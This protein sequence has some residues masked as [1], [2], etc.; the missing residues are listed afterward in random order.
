MPAWLAA[1][2]HV[3]ATTPVTVMPL[4]PL[5]MQI[6]GVVEVKVTGLPEAPPVA[7]AVVVPPTPSVPGVKV[8]V[9]I[10]WFA[11]VMVA[12]DAGALVARL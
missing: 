7:L 8:I 9:P 5:T 12:I 11:G 10:V 6:P 1:I 3:P 4:V 2:V